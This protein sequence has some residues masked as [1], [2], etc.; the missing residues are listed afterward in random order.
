MEKSWDIL[1]ELKNLV[2]EKTRVKDKLFTQEKFTDADVEKLHQLLTKISN[3]TNE[4]YYLMPRKGLEVESAQ[5]L[6]EEHQVQAQMKRVASVL[7]FE[8][9]ERMLMAA[10]LRQDEVNPLDYIYNAIGCRLDPL[11]TN[12]VHESNIILNYLHNGMEKGKYNMKMEVDSIFRVASP[13]D[14]KKRDWCIDN[15]QNSN[16]KLLWHGTKPENAIGILHR[17]LKVN[18]ADVEFTGWI[19][20]K[21]VYFS[22]ESSKSL[23]YCY[24][25]SYGR[26]GNQ[27]GGRQNWCYMFL[28]EVAS[29]KIVKSNELSYWNK[30]GPKIESYD[31]KLVEGRNTSV[32]ETLTVK[33]P[34]IGKSVDCPVGMAREKVSGYWGCQENE[35][36]IRDEKQIT[37]RYLVRVK[38]GYHAEVFG[39]ASSEKSYNSDQ[40]DEADDDDDDESEDE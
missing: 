4:Y 14:V 16:T 9:G 22:D 25:D 17:G 11:T 19:H 33:Y 10:R 18:P 13:G 35:Y 8:I 27:N 28:C 39:E 12:D 1:L 2:K 38:V 26:Y 6:E 15:L 20:G 37:I 31:T 34:S 40:S 24:G 7:E 23:N 36:V 3:L 30:K 21:G 32:S 29:G 5:P